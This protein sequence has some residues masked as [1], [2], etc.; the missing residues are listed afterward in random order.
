MHPSKLASLA[1]TGAKKFLALQT[2]DYLVDDK[3]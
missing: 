3:N 2:F 1:A